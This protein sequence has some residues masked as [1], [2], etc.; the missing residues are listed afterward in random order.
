[1]HVDHTHKFNIS[2][3]MRKEICAP[4]N[5]VHNYKKNYISDSKSPRETL[6]CEKS[7]KSKQLKISQSNIPRKPNKFD[8]YLVQNHQFSVMFPYKKV[9]LPTH[10]P[11]VA[12]SNPSGF[13]VGMSVISVL[14]E[15]PRN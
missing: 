2:Y 11:S 3:H 14:S 1:V 10:R 4:L 5:E 6:W 7:K 8:K 13:M 9:F 12:R 15:N